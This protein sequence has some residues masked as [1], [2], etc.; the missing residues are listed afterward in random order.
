LFAI[1]VGVFPCAPA[2]GQAV[3]TAMIVGT[4][5][6]STGAVMPGVTVRLTHVATD[7][8]SQVQTDNAGYYRTPPLRI[9]EYKI[10]V[11]AQGF[12]KVTRSG[13]VLNVGD[14]RTVDFALEI[15][16]VTESVAITAQAP[17]L[18]TVEGSAGAV[19]EN[20]LVVE[21][22]LNGRDYLQL[23]KISPGV[24]DPGSAQGAQGI[25]V[26]G[27]QGTQVNF[28]IDGIDNNNQT[29]ASQGLQ[30]EALKPQIDAVQEFKVVTNGYSAEYGRSMGG[31]VT[32]T[33]KSG[34]NDLHGTLFFFGRN[35]AVD[36]RNYFTPATASKPPFKRD[37]YGFSVGGPVK[38]NRA[39]LFGDV[40]WTK[41]RQSQ[42]NI[43][44]VPPLP[45]RQGD[46][47][48]FGAPTIYDPTT[49]NAATNTRQPFGGNMIPQTRMDR[50]TTRVLNWWPTP[51]VATAAN[52][53]TWVVPVREDDIN[54]DV[55]YDQT[56][57]A[58][59]NYYVRFSRQDRNVPRI[60][61]LPDSSDGLMKQGQDA[62]YSSYHTALVYNRII[63]SNLVFSLRGGWNMLNDQFSTP[64]KAV[65]PL[66]GVVENNGLDTTLPGSAT[67][68]AS[69]F[70]GLGVQG[71]QGNSFATI[72][73]QTRQE[74]SDFTWM[75]GRHTVKFGQA[76]FWLQSYLLQPTGAL[77]GFSFN[78]QFTRQSSTLTGG[79]PI[80]DMLLGLSTGYSDETFR[81]M[82]LRSPW[83]QQY[84]QDDWRVS[85]RLSLNLGLRYEVNL[86][87]VEKGNRMAN[88]DLDT[89]PN[90]PTLVVAGSK[91]SDWSSRAL[92]NVNMRNLAPRVGFAYRLGQSTVLRGGYGLF[93][94]NLAN[95]GGGEF[96]EINPPYHFAISFSQDPVNP[97]FRV[98]DG[99]PANNLNP[100]NAPAASLSSFQRNGK[101]PLA[102]QWNFNIQ[103]QLPGGIL[104]QIGYFG[105]KANHIVEK[106]DLNYALPGPGAINPRRRF[107]SILF[108]GTTVS[109]P[110][111]SLNSF[112]YSANALYH[113][114]Q[115]R[116]EKRFS[117]GLS[118]LVA[119]TWSKDIG[120]AG[121]IN[122]EASPNGYNAWGVQDP[123]NLRAER[124]LL[125]QDLRHSFV[126]SW[127][128]ELP[129][130]RGKPWGSAWRTLPNAALGG[131]SITGIATL[132][133]GFPMNL[134]VQGDPLNT[135]ESDRP[136]VV[137]DWHLANPSPG[138]WFNKDA[139]AKNQPYRFGNAGRY[140]LQSPGLTN[141]DLAVFK[142]FQP[143]E[144][145]RVQFRAEAFNVFN[146]PP[147]GWAN[148]T[149]G[150]GA[151]GT[152]T[153]AGPPRNLQFGLKLVF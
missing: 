42:V 118:F 97:T 80:A 113:A 152:I 24:S 56:L 74:S 86:P 20:K 138:L 140:I 77:G 64:E 114:L 60:P 34:T 3:D 89:N 65:N 61:G 59:D 99:L 126:G 130:G 51:Q 83:I 81:T 88:F 23:A 151:F 79:Q 32:V 110:L 116:A 15:G 6:D 38:K 134:Q 142:S 8:V 55:R 44:S 7:T 57:S 91:G 121:W 46:F 17:L 53:Y 104:F 128:Y 103:R 120:D 62:D 41:V 67:F 94:A 2:F 144:R 101:S 70:T 35:E 9:G 47:T 92:Q 112:R 139:F 111:S 19:V 78:A 95:T 141:F 43:N 123:T 45:W 148:T 68:G 22:P 102:Q 10:D 150:V 14:I 106:Y 39:F 146:T 37:Q 66:I 108:P 4:V 5:S 16:Q 76:I 129:V 33:T 135:G 40:Q 131:W 72:M 122:G 93:Y 132:H 133:T 153:S 100:A 54:W 149:V 25:S 73:S 1:C 11:E 85:D 12:K 28:L 52:N 75:R 58:K 50:I 90:S 125:Q 29:I 119:Y 71:P 117:K 48:G 124:S 30:K 137:G 31:V 107:T 109:V 82:R 84:V 13:V 26:N 27:S 147:L 98:Q 115:T 105:S 87:W 127:V 49:Y 143:V 21:L 36:A 63:K 136:D 96:M 69:G 18:Q 145:V